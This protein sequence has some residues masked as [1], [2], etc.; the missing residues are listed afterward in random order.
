MRQPDHG[1]AL[2]PKAPAYSCGLA[3]PGPESDSRNRWMNPDMK[4]YLTTI[5]ITGTND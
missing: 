2:S 3:K 5:T 1:G 4:V